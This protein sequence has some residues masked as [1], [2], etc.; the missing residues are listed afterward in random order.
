MIMKK[1]FLL[2]LGISIFAALTSLGA[3][4]EE[5]L[6]EQETEIEV[7]IRKSKKLVE[8]RNNVLDAL[9]DQRLSGYYRNK[10]KLADLGI[11]VDDTTTDFSSFSTKKIFALL[12]LCKNP[13]VLSNI[14][15]YLTAQKDKESQFL[16]GH[17]NQY[18]IGGEKDLSAAERLYQFAGKEGFALAYDRLFDMEFNDLSKCSASS[19]AYL[20]QAALLGNPSSK[21]LLGLTQ[22]T[23]YRK[24]DVHAEHLRRYKLYQQY[25]DT[26]DKGSE[27]MKLVKSADALEFVKLGAES[28]DLLSMHFYALLFEQGFGGQPDKKQ[29][30][31]WFRRAANAG[32]SHSQCKMAELA[33]AEKDFCSA[34][35]YIAQAAVQEEHKEHELSF[36]RFLDFGWGT[37]ERPQLAFHWYVKAAKLGCDK[38]VELANELLDNNS[39]VSLNIDPADMFYIT[40]RL[41]ELPNI[42]DRTL[43]N[44]Q[45]RYADL[46]EFGLGGEENLTLAQEYAALAEATQERIQRA[47]IINIDHFSGFFQNSEEE[48][49]AHFLGKPLGSSLVNAFER[50]CAQQDPNLLKE[51]D[52]VLAIINELAFALSNNGALKEIMWGF[53][54]SASKE[55][56]TLANFE[57]TKMIASDSSFQV[58]TTS[59]ITDVH[60]ALIGYSSSENQFMTYLLEEI[61]HFLM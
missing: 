51:V 8:A 45:R 49:H 1:K 38:S 2:I 36:A 61:N 33:L 60:A 11:V 13:V 42:N 50:H 5:P 29:S 18:G 48:F 35:N 44:A 4:M 14:R 31:Y 30:K 46:L 52:E 34:F 19:I 16:L 22:L 58:F 17:C 20:F 24:D 37:K 28:G 56:Q 10:I 53:L 39:Q 32:Y 23:P 54:G 6:Y 12:K 25:L 7:R 55:V 40:K 43:F 9:F 27:E 57:I 41:V 15:A 3:E 59:E 47:H 21:G 26:L